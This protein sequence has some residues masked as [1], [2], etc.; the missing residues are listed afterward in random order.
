MRINLRQT[1]YDVKR[2]DTTFE[3]KEY[4]KKHLTVGRK[5]YVMRQN[6]IQKLQ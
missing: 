2:Y 1:N 4:L 6:L 3:G 5:G